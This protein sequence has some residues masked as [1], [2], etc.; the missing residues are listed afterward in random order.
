MPARPDWGHRDSPVVAV[1]GLRSVVHGAPFRPRVARSVVGSPDRDEVRAV[2][3]DQGEAQEPAPQVRRN[4][5]L[6]SS[7]MPGDFLDGP[8][9]RR[10]DL[11]PCT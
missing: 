4:G 1:S 9:T 8:S 5:L 10:P 2:A 7:Q 11:V 3:P 6:R